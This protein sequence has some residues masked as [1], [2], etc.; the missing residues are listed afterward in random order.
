[1]DDGKLHLL[2][3]NAFS[4]WK[5]RISERKYD[6]NKGNKIREPLEL[7]GAALTYSYNAL[8]EIPTE[9]LHNTAHGATDYKDWKELGKP[10]FCENDSNNK[11]FGLMH[12]ASSSFRIPSG[13]Y[14][15]YEQ[16]INQK[17]QD[18]LETFVR[19][20]KEDWDRKKLK[21]CLIDPSVKDC[22]EVNNLAPK[23]A[24]SIILAHRDEFGHGEKA[25]GK[26]WKTKRT[27]CFPKIRICR[28]IESQL[29]LAKHACKLLG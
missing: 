28:I 19:E 16:Y 4:E 5:N 10:T 8:Q 24:L 3:K 17:P 14:L 21:E 7:V 11:L 13:L 18:S 6:W 27:E 26:G 9:I 22:C 12:L 29:I 2:R 25:D 20:V 15:A 1:M 23:F